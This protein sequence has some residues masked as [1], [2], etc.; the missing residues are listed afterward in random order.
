MEA[1]GHHKT[2]AQAL[3]QIPLLFATHGSADSQRKNGTLKDGV[4]RLVDTPLSQNSVPLP[5]RS[6]GSGNWT[7]CSG[8]V[9]RDHLGE[10]LWLTDL[11]QSLV[12]LCT[13]SVEL[14]RQRSAST[15]LRV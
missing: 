7:P 15:R 13:L 4:Q 3:L 8:K 6:L 1:L 9:M 11:S 14:V 12:W 2:T 10:A 5:M